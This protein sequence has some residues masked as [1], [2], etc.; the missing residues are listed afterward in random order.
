MNDKEIQ[1]PTNSGYSLRGVQGRIIELIGREI[2]GGVYLPGDLLPREQ[3]LTEKY[4]VSRTSL[5]EAM[6]VLAAKGLVQ[7]RQ[8]SGTRVRPRTHWNAFDGDLFAWSVEEGANEKTIRD[9][10]ELRQL[11]E[12]A[13]AKLAANRATV[14]DIKRLGDALELMEKHAHHPKRYTDADVEFHLG[15]FSASHNTFLQ[16][17]GNLV[18][19]FLRRSLAMQQKV[20]VEV[21]HKPDFSEDTKM[22]QTVYDYIRRGNPDVASDAMLEIVLEAKRSLLEA[23]GHE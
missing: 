2:I 6:K 22:H 10:L 1:P 14:S 15:V 21:L 12:P 4:D 18:A 3:E 7:T 5:R 13:A 20:S 23:I 9:L 8:K 17:F 11:L 19:D 16:Y